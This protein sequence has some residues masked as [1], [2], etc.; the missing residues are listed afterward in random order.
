M[1]IFQKNIP[2][3]DRMEAY[4]FTQFLSIICSISG[5]ALGVWL[6]AISNQNFFFVA[7]INALAFLLSST[8]LYFYRKQLT[9]AP[10]TVKKLE[11]KTSF[12]T[13]AKEIFKLGEE[14]FQKE[15][16]SN[17]ILLLA[18]IAIINALGGSLNAIF[19]LSLLNRPFWNFTFSQSLF[20]IQVVVMAGMV[21]GSLTPRDYF[22]KLSVAQIV[23]WAILPI[24]LI[25]LNQIFFGSQL[26][27]LLSTMFLM[28]LAA[29][30]NPKLNALLLNSLPSDVLAQTSS[31]LSLLFS[32]SLPVGTTLFTALAVWN[33]TICWTVFTL[34]GVLALGLAWKN[35]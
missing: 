15:E 32:L 17:F 14:I 35:R 24:V 7:S 9:H 23:L 8:V 28:Y 18:S 30:V 33:M 13:Q 6:L 20:L 5:Q 26:I 19:N 34:L 12:L 25:G 22:A 4:S 27:T 16:K 3:E 10:V 31:F 11:K 1:P 21:L 2:E 29:K